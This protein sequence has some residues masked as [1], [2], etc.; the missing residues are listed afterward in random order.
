MNIITQKSQLELDLLSIEK[1]VEKATLSLAAASTALN[2]AY[3]SIWELPDDRLLN[4]LQWLVNEQKLQPLLDLHYASGTA[5]NTILD[6]VGH[7]GVRII[8]TVG[9]QF[10]IDEFGTVALVVEDPVI[11]E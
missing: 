10:T 7:N 4:V 6:N 9:R 5:V 2:N 3:S 8:T 1:S 11:E